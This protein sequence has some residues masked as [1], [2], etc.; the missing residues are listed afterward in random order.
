MITIFVNKQGFQTRAPHTSIKGSVGTEKVQFVLDS[1]W[2]DLSVFVEWYRKGMS[3]PV[4]YLL[5]TGLVLFD[6]VPAEVLADLGDVTVGLVGKDGS[7][8]V[9]PTIMMHY[10]TVKE[11]ADPA[12]G[13]EPGQHAQDVLDQMVALQKQSAEDAAAA[14]DAAERAADSVASAGPYA[15]EAKKAAEAAKE[16]QEA[17][18]TSAKQ[19]ANAK[20][21]ANT[22][23]NTAKGHADAAGTAKVAAER[24]AETA[25]N[26]Q[27]GAAQ[28]AQTAA[29]S[30]SAAQAAQ[31][32]AEA[33]AAAF[34]PLTED[35]ANKFL[36]A[37]SEGKKLVFLDPPSGGGD[38]Y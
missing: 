1:S 30:A 35:V 32:A 31:Q 24:A 17:A 33:A 12:G 14:K 3:N 7:T 21:Q 22:A 27:S 4:G 13:V 20:D 25:G 34:P 19:A 15:Q 2:S 8:I 6:T 10:S 18:D 16:S 9:K 28:S 37:D 29:S 5:G 23:S 11:G 36:A 26:A 38:S